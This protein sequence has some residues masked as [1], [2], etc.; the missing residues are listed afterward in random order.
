VRGITGYSTAANGERKSRQWLSNG[1][2][3]TIKRSA[4]RQSW[5]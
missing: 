5:L 1:L 2:P 3:I 4:I